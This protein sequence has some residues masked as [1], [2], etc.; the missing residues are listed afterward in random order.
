MAFVD[1]PYFDA[2]DREQWFNL[3][4]DRNDNPLPD[5]HE[6]PLAAVVA[7]DFIAITSLVLERFKTC[8]P[9]EWFTECPHPLLCDVLFYPSSETGVRVFVEYAFRPST[10]ENSY[11]TDSWWA[12]VQC[13]YVDGNPATGNVDYTIIHFGWSVD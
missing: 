2:S 10:T 8:I 5:N 13:P 12:I 3:E 6:S 7:R 9:D 11:H 1:H 4:T